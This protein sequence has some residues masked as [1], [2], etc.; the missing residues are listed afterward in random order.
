MLGSINIPPLQLRQRPKSLQDTVHVAAVAQVLQ[1]NVPATKSMVALTPSSRVPERRQQIVPCD[2][3]S[4]LA[5][6]HSNHMAGGRL[7]PLQMRS[8][9]N[10]VPT[11]HLH[12]T[13]NPSHLHWY[14]CSRA[15]PGPVMG[16]SCLPDSVMWLHSKSLLASI[17]AS[18]IVFSVFCMA[19]I[20]MPQ[21]E[22]CS[23]CSI[24]LGNAVQAT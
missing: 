21:C 4:C 2:T 6:P 18:A 3:W 20:L 11:F 24:T 16:I 22:R 17:S 13:Y 8:N 14:Q 12:G 9:D 5:S 19:I 23:A 1:T 7:M 15:Y 10:I